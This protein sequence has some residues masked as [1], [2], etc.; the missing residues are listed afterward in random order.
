VLLVLSA[1]SI[2]SKYLIRSPQKSKVAAVIALY[3]HVWF[4]TD[5]WAY[6]RNTDR[7]IG[8][9]SVF[10]LNN[11]S[12]WGK[13]IRESIFVWQIPHGLSYWGGPVQKVLVSLLTAALGHQLGVFDWI[14]QV[15]MQ[16][17]ID[18]E[19]QERKQADTI[20]LTVVIPPL[21]LLAIY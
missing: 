16:D 4:M 9:S 8:P 20:N 15:M 7:W 12:I 11:W 19:R 21:E 18:W 14:S 13:Q 1:F 5:I 10:G 6:R 17:R 2:I 3:F